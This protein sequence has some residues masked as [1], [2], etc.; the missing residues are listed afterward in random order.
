MGKKV[1]AEVEVQVPAGVTRYEV[2]AID[3]YLP[4]KDK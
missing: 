3:K 4:D 2:I 1:G